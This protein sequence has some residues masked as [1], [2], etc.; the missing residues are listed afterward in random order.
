MSSA[1][2]PVSTLEKNKQLLIRW[3]EEVWN[4]G[5]RETIFELFPD[6]IIHDGSA[7]LTAPEE[8]CSFYDALHAQFSDFR[9]SPVVSLAE[10]D[11]ACM[12]WT[13]AFHHTAS[14]KALNVTGTTIVRVENGVFAEAW[15]NWDTASLSAQ[16]SGQPPAPLW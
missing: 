3:F 12:H 8:F 4:Q 7:R 5:R 14:G 9:F 15:Q 16:L 13:I 1:A 2:Q 10:G 6:G 11:L